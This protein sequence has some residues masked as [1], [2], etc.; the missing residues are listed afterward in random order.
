MT[1]N[2]INLPFLDSFLS[3]VPLTLLADISL[4]LAY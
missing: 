3:A 1:A 2:Y 4:L